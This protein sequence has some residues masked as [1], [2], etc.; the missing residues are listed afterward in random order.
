MEWVGAGE[1]EV[2]GEEEEETEKREEMESHCFD[3]RKTTLCDR[4][5]DRIVDAGD[6]AAE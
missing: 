2:E 1:D 4:T 3:G 6:R 5:A